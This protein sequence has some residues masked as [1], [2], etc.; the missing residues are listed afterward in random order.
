MLELKGRKLDDNNQ[1]EDIFIEL[2]NQTRLDIL[3]RISHTKLKLSS[4]S[5]DLK[6]PMPEIHRNVARLTEIELIKRDP[7]GAF[8]LTPFGKAILAQVP[9]FEVLSRH[10]SFFSDHDLNGLPQEFIQRMGAFRNSEFL[11]AT[12]G[13]FGALISVLRNILVTGDKYLYIMSPLVMNEFSEMAFS[14]AH[15]KGTSLHLIIP[16]DGSLGDKIEHIMQKYRVKDLMVKK[17]VERKISAVH[18][19]VLVSDTFAAVCFPN[20]KGDVDIFKLFHGNDNAF[21]KW[22]LDYF[23]YRW[24]ELS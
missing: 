14:I 11:D 5:T 15:D 22:C 8:S 17:T 3:H 2:G 24:N 13:G 21:H 19:A 1:L 7:E 4:L 9:S 20:D 23:N 18:F 10:K 16:G 12:I 6:L